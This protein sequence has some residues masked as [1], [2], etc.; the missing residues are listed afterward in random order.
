[1]KA[2]ALFCGNTEPSID[3]LMGDPILQVLMNRDGVSPRELRVLIAT[4]RQQQR[5]RAVPPVRIWRRCD[6]EA[7]KL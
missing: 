4:V 5:P 7:V 6:I 1:M 2:F 3:E